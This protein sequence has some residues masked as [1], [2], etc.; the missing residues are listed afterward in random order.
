VVIGV[1]ILLLGL[2]FPV[3][4]AFRRSGQLTKSMSNLRQI[5]SWM[6]IYSGD[7][8]DFVVPSQFN[9]KPDPNGNAAYAG[10]VRSVIGTGALSVG[11]PHRGTWADILWTVFKLG[12][13]PDVPLDTDARAPGQDYAYDSPDKA[14]Y[15]WCWGRL[16]SGKPPSGFEFNNPL[17]SAAPNSRDFRSPHD[18]PTPYGSGAGEKGMPGYFAA[19]NFFNADPE[20]RDARYPSREMP[21]ARYRTNAQIRQP[22][23]SLYLVDSFAGEIIQPWPI[24]WDVNPSAGNGPSTTAADDSECLVDFRYG[25]QCLFLLLDG[26][27]EPQQPWDTLIDLEG[28]LTDPDSGNGRGFRINDLDKRR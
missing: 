22:E 19:N 12:P 16:G 21:E 1:I 4:G 26:H 6:K 23:Q 15:D 11:E 8:R 3:L 17:R 5:A 25:D 9:Y 13:F 24:Y 2:L 28:D 20:A 14:L 7:N 10:K 27:V 18:Y